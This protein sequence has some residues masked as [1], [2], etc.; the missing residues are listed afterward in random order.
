MPMWLSGESAKHSHGR[1]GGISPCQ[2]L[3]KDSRSQ[4]SGFPQPQTLGCKVHRRS[5]CVLL[6]SPAPMHRMKL[7]QQVLVRYKT[8]VS[9]VALA[10]LLQG[11]D[12]IKCLGIS[13]AVAHHPERVRNVALRAYSLVMLLA[14]GVPLALLLQLAGSAP[15][16]CEALSVGPRVY[17][18]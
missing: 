11:W 15:V 9:I 4:F 8:I 18:V 2:G 12:S 7:R 10:V 16:S 14:R 3:E 5:H 1:P 13:R 6:N 17:L